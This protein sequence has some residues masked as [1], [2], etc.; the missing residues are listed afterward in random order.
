MSA[1]STNKA[2][3]LIQKTD[4]RESSSESPSSFSVGERKEN[5][6]SDGNDTTT[7]RSRMMF[8]QPP[9]GVELPPKLG[10]GTA[11]TDTYSSSTMM[12]RQRQT[13]KQRRL[14]PQQL[15]QDNAM[16]QQQQVDNE[17]YDEGMEDSDTDFDTLLFDVY[18]SPCVTKASNEEFSI[19]DID[20][21]S[22]CNTTFFGG[23][24]Y[25][26]VAELLLDDETTEP[27]NAFVPFSVTPTTTTTAQRPSS[28]SSSSK[29]YILDVE[30]DYELYYRK[31][32]NAT[33]AMRLLSGIMLEHLASVTGL[34]EKNMNNN[35]NNNVV[36]DGCNDNSRRRNRILNEEDKNSNINN[37][38]SNNKRFHLFTDDELERFVAISNEQNDYFDPDFSKSKSLGMDG[39]MNMHECSP[40]CVVFV[41]VCGSSSIYLLAIMLTYKRIR[42]LFS[43]VS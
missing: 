36:G 34:N 24:Q 8:P 27:T 7:I 26:S 35:M 38:K 43:F 29:Y 4:E 5:N 30:Y 25:D 18:E 37:N 33:K 23:C 13:R 31:T 22:Q 40:Q 1:T 3:L 9:I 19:S 10:G 16:S 32:A 11:T 42:A 41:A 14:L 15:G 39:W 21:F 20:N 6:C 28:S 12:L 2:R 17:Y